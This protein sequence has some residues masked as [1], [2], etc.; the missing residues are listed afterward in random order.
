[1]TALR[2]FFGLIWPIILGLGAILLASLPAG[3]RPG[4]LPSPDFVF[5]VLFFWVAHRPA[6]AP[7]P[8]LCAVLLIRD[9]IID[10][11]IGAR[12]FAGL[13]TLEILRA[14]PPKMRFWTEL[15][16]FAT[17]FTAQTVIVQLLLTV[18]LSPTP[19]WRPLM[20]HALVTIL[21]YPLIRWPLLK[22]FGDTQTEDG[23]FR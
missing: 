22:L 5:A 11:P 6:A 15:L 1:M 10:G 12:A 20:W 18:T 23:R 4:A 13:M 19:D 14:R 16:A 8:S 7:A 2:D 3:V 9:L 17:T 21:A